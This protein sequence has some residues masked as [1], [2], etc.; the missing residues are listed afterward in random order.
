MSMS[1]GAPYTLHYTPLADNT[2]QLLRIDY[3]L[4][5]ALALPL[6]SWEH[7][8]LFPVIFDSFLHALSATAVNAVAQ[9]T[10]TTNMFVCR[11]TM[12]CLFRQFCLAWLQ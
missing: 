12:E 9:R 1:L 3:S 6:L 8:N 2:P 11:E 7:L 10:V 5:L 4:S